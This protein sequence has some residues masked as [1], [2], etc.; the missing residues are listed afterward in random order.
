MERGERGLRTKEGQSWWFGVA[1]VWISAEKG[2]DPR[3]ILLEPRDFSTIFSAGAAVDSQPALPSSFLTAVFLAH[4]A[5]CM[6]AILEDENP[7]VVE[8]DFFGLPGGALV[9][10]LRLIPGGVPFLLVSRIPHIGTQ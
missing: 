10:A 6:A 4:K 7:A 8:R 9:K 3:P 2:P 1:V 5:S